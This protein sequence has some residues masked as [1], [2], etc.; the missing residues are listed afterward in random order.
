MSKTESTVTHGTFSLERTYPVPARR[1][2]AA[3]SDKNTKRRWFV[4]GEGWDVEQYEAFPRR[5]ARDLALP[6]PGR[7]GDHQRHDLSGHRPRAPHRL[8]LPHGGGR[9]ADL[10]LADH[11]RARACPERFSGWHLAALHRA[12]A[13]FDDPKALQMREEDCGGLLEA[14]AKELARAA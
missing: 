12:G 13:F 3:F 8:R 4:E 11:D 2:F 9:Q 10:G 7:A 6:L 14:L 1:V 5:G